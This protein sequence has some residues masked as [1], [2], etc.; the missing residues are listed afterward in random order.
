MKQKKS[1]TLQPNWF[2]NLVDRTERY[3]SRMKLLPVDFD[4]PWWDIIW[5]QKFLFLFTLVT[6][7]VWT[8]TDTLFPLLV[9]LVFA[10]GNW[11]WLGVL[12]GGRIVLNLWY[13]I[14]FSFNTQ[15][16]I[17]TEQSVEV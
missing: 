9:G 10:S 15:S 8:I 7:I 12:F 5:Q 6:E 14:M 11:V 16:A 17:Q 4:K 1:Q 3:S 13:N 2:Y